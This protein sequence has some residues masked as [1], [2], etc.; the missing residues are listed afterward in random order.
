MKELFDDVVGQSPLD[1]RESSRQSSAAP[2]RRRFY[3]DV[4]V[5]ESEGGFTVTL[6]GKP[7]RTPSQVIVTIPVRDLA[8]TIAAEWDA[9]QDIIDPL[10]MPL[11]RLANSIVQGVV[12]RADLVV[13]DI[14]KY[15]GS[16]LLFYHAEFPEALA[17]KQGEHWDPVLRWAADDLGAHFI[18]AQGI[19]PVRQ[20]EQAI[21]NARARLPGDPWRIG[22]L[23]VVTT[24]TGSALLA[25]A[26]HEAACDADAV[27][28]AAHVDED[29]NASQWGIDE[30]VASRRAARRRDFDAA[31]KVVTTISKKP[32]S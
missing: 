8:E 12:G 32:V 10:T 1:P 22:A 15:F 26:L 11:T 19:M 30:E 16:D 29:W 24:I 14:A 20:P 3:K 18:L 2:K 31:V 23:H 28:A 9:Q 13:D 7:I 17:A 4:G 25:L 27:W 6:D 21:A 5:A